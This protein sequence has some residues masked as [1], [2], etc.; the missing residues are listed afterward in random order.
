MGWGEESLSSRE[1]SVGVG[2]RGGGVEEAFAEAAACI[3]FFLGM[4][5]WGDGGLQF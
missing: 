5:E 2:G 4:G 1:A 3:F